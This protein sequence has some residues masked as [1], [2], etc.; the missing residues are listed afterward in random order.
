MYKVLISPKAQIEIENIYKYIAIDKQDGF[1]A[2]HTITLINQKILS[3]SK[4]PE[5]A[6]VSEQHPRYRIAHAKRYKIFYRINKTKKTVTVT[7]VVHS[8]QNY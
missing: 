8:L 5:A 4:V 7:R 3:L 1:A 2:N 6:A